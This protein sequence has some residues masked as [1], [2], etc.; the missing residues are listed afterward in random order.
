MITLLIKTIMSLFPF[1]KEIV[2]SLQKG[3]RD[4]R[5][6]N[7]LT[8]WLVICLVFMIAGG[9]TG[10]HYMIGLMS[11]ERELRLENINLKHSLDL[12]QDTKEINT[13][14]KRNN[15][16]IADQY[17]QIKEELSQ[18][19]DKLAR[20]HEENAELRK[21]MANIKDQLNAA[22]QTVLALQTDKTILYQQLQEL[23][24][25][26]DPPA[27]VAEQPAKPKRVSERVLSLIQAVSSN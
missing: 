19:N 24:A 23:L 6:K 11:S 4:R 12:M 20:A 13:E 5:A 17:L 8:P 2:D 18:A 7:P 10:G 25:K 16:K 27:V 3:P 26:K 14:L 9:A 1:V 21:E 15:R 22:N